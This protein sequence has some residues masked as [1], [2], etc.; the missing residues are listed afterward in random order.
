[1]MGIE[2]VNNAHKKPGYAKL[3]TGKC[4]LKVVKVRKAL[5]ITN[6]IYDIIF[7]GRL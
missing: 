5:A 3:M 6:V 2:R 1:M 4:K 7:F